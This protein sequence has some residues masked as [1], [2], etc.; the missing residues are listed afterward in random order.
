MSAPT[1][2]VPTNT[3]TTTQPEMKKIETVPATSPANTSASTPATFPATTPATAPAVETKT[4][5]KEETK[6]T[7]VSKYR[8]L[9]YYFFASTAGLLVS[10][11]VYRRF[12]KR[13]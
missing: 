11:F 6:K 4:E 5:N 10:Y 3:A 1:T 7:G 12:Q 8:K 9:V 13:H 2:Q